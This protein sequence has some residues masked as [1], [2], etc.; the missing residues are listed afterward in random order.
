[1]QVKDLAENDMVGLFFSGH[2]CP[3]S[4]RFTPLLAHAYKT[5]RAAGKNVEIVFLSSDKD[6]AH[7]TKFANASEYNAPQCVLFMTSNRTDF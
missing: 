6:Q 1:M 5:M 3:P 2:W 4:Q 7:I